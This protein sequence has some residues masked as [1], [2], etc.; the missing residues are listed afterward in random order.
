LNRC[1]DSFSKKAV[2]RIIETDKIVK[3][4][5]ST[6]TSF[7]KHSNIEIN[8]DTPFDF[9]HHEL[10]S[11]VELLR[12]TKGKDILMFKPEGPGPNAF[13]IEFANRLTGRAEIIRR[14]SVL[15]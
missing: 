3:G 9:T 12:V 4:R 11:L 6:Y 2:N 15:Y 13:T 7:R 10:T 5:S 8:S 14:G 1:L